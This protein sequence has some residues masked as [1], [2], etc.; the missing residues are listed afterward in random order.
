MA[1]LPLLKRRGKRDE[2]KIKKKEKVGIKIRI[3]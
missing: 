2:P 1:L 3:K